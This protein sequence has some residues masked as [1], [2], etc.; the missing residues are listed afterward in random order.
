MI[1]NPFNFVDRAEEYKIAREIVE[2]TFTWG[3]LNPKYRDMS[4]AAG[5][6]YCMFHPNHHSPSGKFYEDEERD[7]LVFHCF[8]ERRTFTTYDYVD[9]IM[10]KQDQEYKDVWDFLIKEL[11]VDEVSEMIDL[12]RKKMS[13]ADS[14]LLEKKVE[15]ITNVYNK[16]DN[17]IEFIDSLYSEL[18]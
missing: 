1:I 3:D 6:Q 4:S 15:Y 18:D 2:Q 7:I 14:S 8:A 11:G 10:C 13:I 5:N 17:V 12:V 16:Y 9:L